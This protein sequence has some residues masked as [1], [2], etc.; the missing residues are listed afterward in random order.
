MIGHLPTAVGAIVLCAIAYALRRVPRDGRHRWL[1]PAWALVLCVATLLWLFEIYAV[2]LYSVFE[3]FRDPAFATSPY[4][5]TSPRAR[6]ALTG[7]LALATLCAAIALD[8]SRSCFASNCHSCLHELLDAQQDCPECGAPRETGPMRGATRLDALAVRKP[9]LAWLLELASLAIVA[10]SFM[11]IAIAF[12]PTLRAQSSHHIRQLHT[13]DGTA[14][15]GEATVG[16]E[17]NHVL[18]PLL[19]WLDWRLDKLV[20]VRVTAE[21]AQA[22]DAG[23]RTDLT[24]PRT[25]WTHHFIDIDINEEIRTID[26]YARLRGRIDADLLPSIDRSRLQARIE[27]LMVDFLGL[28]ESDVPKTALATGPQKPRMRNGP[29]QFGFQS[30][31]QVD[32]WPRRYSNDWDLDRRDSYVAALALPCAVGL[33]ATAVF[34]WPPTTPH[35]RRARTRSH[36]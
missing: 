28:P 17:A 22:E 15:L 33:L 9:Q 2:E 3:L 29:N 5:E 7:A 20:R 18:A 27:L 32:E 4:L 13:F 16:T 31:M 10:S 24:T 34:L 21:R 19:P 8:L 6:Y 23:P 11:A 26:D 36:S 25:A 30:W 1:L 12:V 14:A 35:A